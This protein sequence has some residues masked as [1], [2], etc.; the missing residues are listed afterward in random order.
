MDC[1]ILIELYRIF[2]ERYP[3]HPK[4]AAA[5]FMQAFLYETELEEKDVEKK[6]KYKEFIENYPEHP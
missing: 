2:I 1:T 4:V 5:V 6:A 3:K